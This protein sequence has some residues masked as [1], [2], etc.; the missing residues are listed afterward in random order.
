MDYPTIEDVRVLKGRHFGL[1]LV[2]MAKCDFV[3]FLNPVY[4]I[5][6][7]LN[8]PLSILCISRHLLHRSIEHDIFEH[9]KVYRVRLHELLKLRLGQ[10]M[11]VL[12]QN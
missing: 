1:G 9:I 6:D 11:R 7:Q 8:F 12:Y 4:S 5:D 2:P 10:V 3:K